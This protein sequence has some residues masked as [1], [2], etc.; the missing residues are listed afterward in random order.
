[1]YIDELSGILCTI[2]YGCY[3]NAVCVNHLVYADDTVLIAPSPAA[4]QGLIDTACKYFVENGL[5]LNKKKTRCMAIKPV[6]NKDIHIPS[7]YVHGAEISRVHHH[8]YLGYEISDDMS[9]DQAILKESRGLYIRGNTISR[10]FKTC[11]DEVKKKLFTSY[12][13]SFYCCAL[14]SIYKKK[15]LQDLHVAHN[16]V[17]RIIFRLP[18][19][20]SISQ[21]FVAHGIPNFNIL[22]RRH[23]FSL[24]TRILSTTNSIIN[25]ITDTC[26]LTSTMFQEW[27][28]ELF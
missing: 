18:R 26:T 27:L 6:C 7:F 20:T 2:P 8:S 17:F 4:L 1:M 10:K 14:W 16:N 25:V 5:M 3:V 9:D 12:C 11:N 24:Y 15:N 13:T 21:R 23:M 28:H 19:R 22:M